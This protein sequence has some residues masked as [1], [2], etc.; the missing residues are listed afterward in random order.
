MILNLVIA[1][2]EPGNRPLLP[3]NYQY[4]LSAII[5]KLIFSADADFATFLHDKGY[6]SKNHGKVF[7]LFTFSDLKML[8][9]VQADRMALI[10]K[11]GFLKVCFHM[12]EAT[13]AFVKGLFMGQRFTVGDAA[14]SVQFRVKDVE[15]LQPELP[16]AVD[17][18]VTTVLEPI[19]PLVVGM[20][21]RMA[22]LY[23]FYSPYDECW[24]EAL[25]FSW[26]E[27]YKVVSGDVTDIRDKIKVEPII[28]EFPPLKRTIT[29]KAGRSDA[30][31]L[32]GYT[33]FRFKVTA[34][35]E[36]IELALNSG[37]GLK[38]S[39]GMGCVQITK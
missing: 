24:S 7:K 38:N 15:N 2:D 13:E 23:Q 11:V 32:R 18:M 33:K 5:Y 31:K 35:K 22:K 30:Q 8:F 14:S 26:I 6:S 20:M 25:I 37:L 16:E 28:L 3:F 39:I 36:M 10:D 27:K 17:N 29:I 1:V 34:P 19:S 4:P 12:P 21:S 9:N